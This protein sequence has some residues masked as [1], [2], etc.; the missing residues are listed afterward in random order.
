MLCCLNI[1]IC[2]HY[3]VKLYCKYYQLYSCEYFIIR[4]LKEYFINF[5]DV[6]SYFFFFY[7]Q[8]NNISRYTAILTK[9]K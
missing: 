5:F 7:I 1:N 8:S 6:F 9:C 3:A 4:K 2:S